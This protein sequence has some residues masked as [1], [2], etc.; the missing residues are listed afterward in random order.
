MIDTRLAPYGAFALRAALGIMFIAHA[1]LKIAVFTVPGFAGFL[2]QVGFPA[3]L[4]WPIILAEL[5]GGVAILLGLY[6][7]AVSVALLPVLLGALLVH[8]PNGWVFNATNGGW[9]YPAFL[10]LAA[11]AHALIGDGAYAIRPLAPGL[12]SGTVLRPRIG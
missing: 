7:R 11:V 9:E 8:A 2:T 1:Y 12:G 4:A 5:I 6:G 3:F 10:A